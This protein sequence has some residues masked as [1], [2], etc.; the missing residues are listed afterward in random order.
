[1]VLRIENND[2]AMADFTS[3]HVHFPGKE[4]WNSGFGEVLFSVLF[5]FGYTLKQATQAFQFVNGDFKVEQ[6]LDPIH[7]SSL[8]N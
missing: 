1:V 6:A 2:Y 7:D 4:N 5:L 3:V 8:R